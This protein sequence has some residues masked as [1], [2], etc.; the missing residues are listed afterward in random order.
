MVGGA[1]TSILAAFL[2]RYAALNDKLR[3]LHRR[4]SIVLLSIYHLLYAA[5]IILALSVF[6]S[7]DYSRVMEDLKEVEWVINDKL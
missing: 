4:S 1:A 2:Y 6:A 5:P 3:L 7:D